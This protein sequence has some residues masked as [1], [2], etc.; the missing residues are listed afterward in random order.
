MTPCY[1][2]D[3]FIFHQHRGV[4]GTRGET[5]CI[6]LTTP[7]SN[8]SNPFKYPIPKGSDGPPTPIGISVEVRALGFSAFWH[9]KIFGLAKNSQENSPRVTKN[10]FQQ[11]GLFNS[12][13][14]SS[15]PRKKKH[16]SYFPLYWLVHRDPFNGLFVSLYNWVVSSCIHPKQT[17]FLS[18]DL[19][20]S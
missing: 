20:I 13:H 16:S 15:E 12:F 18:L 2:G 8:P 1:I 6:V 11:T 5:L 7:S 14:V 19:P 9:P 3:T 17:G 10:M 4:H